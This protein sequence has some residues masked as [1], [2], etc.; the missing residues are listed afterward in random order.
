VYPRNGS[1]FSKATVLE[2]GFL[3][4]H[5]SG[6]KLAYRVLALDAATVQKRFIPSVTP[7]PQSLTPKNFIP[8]NCA[9]VFP[10]GMQCF[11]IW[12]EKPSPLDGGA[13]RDGLRSFLHISRFQKIGV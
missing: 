11:A 10:P 5:A 3:L 1:R 13:S 7:P 4:R 9:S 2:R 6:Q 12:L 8:E